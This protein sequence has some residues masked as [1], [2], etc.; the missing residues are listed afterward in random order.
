MI[1]INR[2]LFGTVLH[3]LCALSLAGDAVASYSGDGTLVDNG[4]TSA[5]DRYVLNIGS[6]SFATTSSSTFTLKGLPREKFVFGF[7]LRLLPNQNRR[8]EPTLIS[9]TALISIVDESGKTLFTK[10]TKLNEWT[11]SIHSPGD[12]AFIYGREPFSTDLQASR[13]KTY[14]LTV[15][16][17]EPDPALAIYSASVVAKAGGW[18]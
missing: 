16:V 12:Y 3:A 8:L 17:I 7:E 14:K 15:A 4:P 2:H 9:A 13:G 5:T 6:I 1:H 18:K 10:H 11:W